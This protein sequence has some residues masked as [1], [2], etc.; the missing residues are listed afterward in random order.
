MKINNLTNKQWLGV[1]HR[2]SDSKAC[3][4]IISH[5]IIWPLGLRRDVRDRDVDL[6]AISLQVI[7]V[8]V[9]GDEFSY[10]E[11]TEGERWQNTSVQVKQN[12]VIIDI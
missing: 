10:G 6:R 9:K 12:K 8:V 2:Q 4:C 7:P 1:E 5:C 11:I 3:V